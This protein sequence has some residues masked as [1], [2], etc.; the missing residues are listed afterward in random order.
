MRVLSGGEASS[1]ERWLE[2]ARKVALQSGCLRARCG[3]VIVKQFGSEEIIASAC[4][5]PPRN[6]EENSRCLRKHEIRPGFKSD[7]TC[8]IHAEQNAIMRAMH[9]ADVL[10]YCRLYHSPKRIPSL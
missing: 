7:R 10:P 1:A 6:M 5:Q 2:E 3:T 8:C 4:N 9:R